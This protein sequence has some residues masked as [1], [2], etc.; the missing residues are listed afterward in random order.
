MLNK[1]TKLVLI[2]VLV[3]SL[4]G[5]AEL[6]KKFTPKKKPGKE[7]Y[8]FY[9]IEDYKPRPAP[10]RY[11]KNYILWHNWHSELER[12][13]DTSYTRDVF[14]A[15]ETLKYLTAMRDLLVEEQA[16]KLDAQIGDMRAV[17]DYIEKRMECI[18]DNVRNRRTVERVGRIVQD[19]FSYKR[20]RN[21]IK[22][23]D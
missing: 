20:M 11:V 1:F 12:A 21:Y 4:S 7:D 5:C 23:E 19:E 2:A 6:A 16:K 17:V 8:S 18:K 15:N 3:T 13:D 10:E 9:Q 22:T 14:N